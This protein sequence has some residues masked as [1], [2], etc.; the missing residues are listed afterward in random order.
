MRKNGDGTELIDCDYERGSVGSEDVSPL[1]EAGGDEPNE[2][3]IIMEGP[4]VDNSVTQDY[5]AFEQKVVNWEEDTGVFGD[6]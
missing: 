2:H 4:A 6:S 5:L 1:P 3:L